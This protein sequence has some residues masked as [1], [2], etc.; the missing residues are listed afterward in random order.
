MG[1]MIDDTIFNQSKNLYKYDIVE[2][3]KLCKK[4][5]D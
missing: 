4:R 3:C 2:Q 1:M 5:L